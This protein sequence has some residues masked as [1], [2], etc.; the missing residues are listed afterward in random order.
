MTNSPLNKLNTLV[1]NKDRL[2]ELKCVRPFQAIKIPYQ[3]H[4]TPPGNRGRD[5]P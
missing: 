3:S 2:V 5:H 4:N 1:G